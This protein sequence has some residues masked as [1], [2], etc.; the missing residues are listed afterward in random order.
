MHEPVSN[1]HNV[2]RA[3]F[4]MLDIIESA[5]IATVSPD[6][7]PWNTPVYFGRDRATFYWVSRVEAQHSS[8][9]RHNPHT[10][11]VVYDSGRQD[12]TGTAVYIE[13]DAAELT[14]QRAIE[15]AAALIYRRR[16]KSVPSVEGFREP[17]PIAFIG[18]QRS[19]LGPTS[20]MRPIRFRGISALKS[21]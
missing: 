12:V 19:G 4:K 6:G 21:N 5:T 7:R 10:F 11:I 8:N 3:A 2:K 18:Q 20:Y 1:D 14:D 16:R 9:L 15:F 13:A 17:S